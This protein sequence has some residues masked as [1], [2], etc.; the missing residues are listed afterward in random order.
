MDPQAVLPATVPTALERVI[1]SRTFARS[2]RHRS[3]LRHLVERA[4]AGRSGE[5]KESTIAL[6]VFGRDSY[7]PQVDA[8]VRV[9]VGKLRE[10]L[11]RYYGTEGI[12]ETVRFVI[13]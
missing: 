9:E 12:G 1:G 3:L 5:I 10:R 8:Q 11:E 2:E 13:P 4:V 7:D 6:E